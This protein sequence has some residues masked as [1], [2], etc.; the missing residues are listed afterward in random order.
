MDED[1]SPR[2]FAVLMEAQVLACCITSA[3]LRAPAL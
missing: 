1:L 2:A 3:A